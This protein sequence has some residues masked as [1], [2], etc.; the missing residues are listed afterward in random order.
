MF[1]DSISLAPALK[2]RPRRISTQAAPTGF[3]SDTRVR[4]I[5]GLRAVSALRPGDLLLDRDGRIVELRDMRERHMRAENLV[6]I[7]ASAFG[8]GLCGA[9]V[10]RSLL[11]G[12]GQ[13]IGTR[14]WRTD[15]LFGGAALTPARKLVDGLHVHRSA[16][17][18]TLFDLQFD[19]DVILHAN[20]LT[21]L[22][23]GS[24]A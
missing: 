18:A 20:G 11:V 2:P 7:D 9:R 16:I 13:Q 4:T 15:I 5:F 17:S 14:D 6:R 12:A 22:V 3:A 24:D 1:A 23:G 10:P 19:M 21:A 8:L